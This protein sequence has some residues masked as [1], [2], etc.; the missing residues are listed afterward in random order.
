[1]KHSRT[2]DI[3]FQII[4]WAV[5]IIVLVITL[6][7]LIYVATASFKSNQELMLG[8]VKILPEEPTIQNYI[9]AWK[10]AR[11]DKLTLNSV[12]VSVIAVTGVLLNASISAYV[13][14]RGRFPG[15]KTLYNI[16][17]ATMFISAGSITLFPIVQTAVKLGLNNLTGVAIVSIFTMSAMNLFLSI[18]Y[19]KTISTEIDEAAKIDG[20]S[21]FRI[22]WN[23][24]LP[25]SKPVL[26]TIGLVTFR[27]VW[28]DYLMPMV[29]LASKKD[30]YTLVVGIVQLKSMGGEGAAQW[31]LMMAGTMFS[32]VPII[33]VYLFLNRYFISGLT[34]GSVK[35]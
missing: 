23:I 12:Y 3:F 2:K 25:L 35:G 14:S 7:P 10:L 16:F 26:A 29:M 4:K 34:A 6:I 5:L 19:M 8:S 31:N 32:I 28:N 9:D 18:G 22:Y 1:M 20:C 11:F 17:L 21:F 13:F 15:K 24:I 30:S 33:V 27:T